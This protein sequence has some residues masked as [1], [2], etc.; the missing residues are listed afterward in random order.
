MCL[1]G[2]EPL[3]VSKYSLKADNPVHILYS[4]QLGG[5]NVAS[6]ISIHEHII[7]NG[8]EVVNPTMCFSSLDSTH[9]ESHAQ[10]NVPN[11]P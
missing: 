8:G 5:L 3:P 9:G 6:T 7:M 4:S 2:L 1:A 11:A 10:S